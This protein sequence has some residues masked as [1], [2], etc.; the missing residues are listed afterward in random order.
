VAGKKSNLPPTPPLLNLAIKKREY[1]ARI[2]PFKN[3]HFW[4][5]FVPMEKKK[6]TLILPARKKEKKREGYECAMSKGP[7][8]LGRE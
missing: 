2:F 7:W 8:T 6:R 3:P 4:R 1:L 5:N